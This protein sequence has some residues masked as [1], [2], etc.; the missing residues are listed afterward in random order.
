MKETIDF[1]K[2]MTIIRKRFL[3]ILLVSLI[4]LVGSYAVTEYVISP[5]YEAVTRL[6]VSRP[7]VGNQTVEL[8]DI[9]T[10]IQLINTYRDVINDPVVL[11]EV[12]EQLS[13]EMSEGEL[14]NRVTVQIQQDSQIFGVRVTGDSPAKAAEVANLVAE[15]F[16]NNVGRIINVDNVSILSPAKEVSDPISPRLTIN[17]VIGLLFGLI[18]GILLALLIYVLDKKVYEEEDV[19]ELMHWNNIGSISQITLKPETQKSHDSI[20]V[21]IDPEV[22]MVVSDW[23]P[24]EATDQ[25]LFK[26]GTSRV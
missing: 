19:T 10:N 13:F 5:Q 20:E 3:L 22:K 17:L 12:R 6:I 25:P 2:L 4:G 21:E 9:Q 7:Y 15:T 16:Q 1:L 18:S 23:N 24:S 26:E 8:G 11:D 14:L